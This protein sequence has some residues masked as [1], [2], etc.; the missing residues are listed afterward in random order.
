MSQPW[1]P[2][3]MREPPKLSDRPTGSPQSRHVLL[4]NPFYAKDPHASFGKHVL[5]PTLAL[6]ALA[7]ATPADWTVRIW[8]ENLLA[9]TPPVHPMPWIVG[10]TVHLTFAARAYELAD[11][12]RARGALVVLGGLHVQSCPGEATPHADAIA[13]GDG[14]V[15]WPRILA[16]A[17]VGRLQRIYQADFSNHY[18][19][20]PEPRRDLLP[21]GAFLTTASLNAT[22]GC[23][24]R[25]GF[26]YLATDGLTMPYRTRD[27]ADIA[28]AI[29]AT[30]EPYAVFTD[31]NLGSRPD[32]MLELCAALKPLGIIW[33]AAISLDVTDHPEVVRAMA[34]A[35]C[36]GVFI[37]FE[38]LT[39]GNLEDAR[40][41]TPR[42]EEYA[43]RVRLLHDH[44]IQVNA[45]FVFGFDHDQADVFDKTAAW[46]ETNRVECGTFH[47]LTPYPGTPLFRQMQAEGRLRHTDWTRYDTAHCVFHPR[48][49]TPEEL[50]A[51]YARIYRRIFSYASIWKRR[52]RQITAV[53]AYLAM[54][55]LYKKSN[56][57]WW[58][59]IRAKLVHAVWRPLVMLSAWRHR[60]WRRRMVK[61]DQPGALLPASV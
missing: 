50:E 11:W 46:L 1:Q 29:S 18:A 5:T 12:Y 17:A 15:V 3:A 32:Y 33:S 37:G 10:I 40:K 56:L 13:I 45:S 22:R 9:G 60:R 27:P 39:D 44:G 31:N 47:L 24:N 43:A 2:K 14:V 36:T 16:D 34:E 59:L 25:C 19:A 51:G 26:C 42:A 58:L 38:S 7:A 52:P 53:P 48:H 21:A 54:S 8:D 57:L 35:G 41:R 30:G 61:S 20:Q 6:T 49:M 28:A 4:I 55:M 23:H